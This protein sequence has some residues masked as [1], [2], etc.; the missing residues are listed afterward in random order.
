MK[1]LVNLSMWLNISMTQ[2]ISKNKL[3]SINV[4]IGKVKHMTQWPNGAE[5]LI[6]TL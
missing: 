2:N 1:K 5:D 4:K 6:Y 3:N